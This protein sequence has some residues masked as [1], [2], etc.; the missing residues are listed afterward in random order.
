MEGGVGP[1][2][3]SWKVLQGFRLGNVVVNGTRPPR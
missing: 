1:G 2:E 3:N